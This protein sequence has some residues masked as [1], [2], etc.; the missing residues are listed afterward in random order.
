VKTAR[1]HF[2]GA[3]ET[4]D[5]R[6]GKNN[7]RRKLASRSERRNKKM[8]KWRWPRPLEETAHSGAGT[9]RPWVS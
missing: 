4:A 2:K 1:I 6:N 5:A 7:A 3:S 9:A 8:K